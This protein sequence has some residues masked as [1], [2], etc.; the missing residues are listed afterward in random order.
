MCKKNE[1]QQQQHVKFG[2]ST[3]LNHFSEGIWAFHFQRSQ[4][5]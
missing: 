2:I 1:Q 5:T 3:A 4:W